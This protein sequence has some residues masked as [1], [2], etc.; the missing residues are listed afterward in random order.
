MTIVS[1]SLV[2]KLADG[3]VVQ[4]PISETE[5]AFVLP[6]LS[7]FDGGTLRVVPAENIVFKTVNELESKQ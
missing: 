7:G 4:R 1:A 6:V 2:L 3:R 5:C